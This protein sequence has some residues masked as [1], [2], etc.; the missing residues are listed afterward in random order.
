MKWT[1]IPDGENSPEIL[2]LAE[3]LNTQQI[4]NL[5]H[6]CLCPIFLKVDA[7]QSVSMTMDL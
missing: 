7:K 6:L 1:L 5:Y 3:F 4:Y 2:Q